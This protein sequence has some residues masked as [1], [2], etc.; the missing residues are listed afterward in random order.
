MTEKMNHN[1]PNN[2][3]KFSGNGKAGFFFCSFFVLQVLFFGLCCPHTVHAGESPLQEL[4]DTTL[5][6]FKAI[7]GKITRVEDRKA[8]IDIGLNEGL[9]PGMRLTVLREQAPFRHPVTKEVLGNL[10]SLTGRMEIQEV[11]EDSA[12][13]ILLEGETQEGDKA[14]ISEV[15]VDILFCQSKEVDWQ[16]AD[17]YHKKLK[18]TGRFT[19]RDTALETDNPATAIDEA[20]KLGAEV[21]LLLSSK[22]G[23]KGMVFTQRLF[24][25]SDGKK[26]AETGVL[27]DTSL[28]KELR[29]GEQFFQIE[30]EVALKFD[31]SFSA[32]FVMTGDV[33]GDGKE[34]II[35]ATD[36]DVG[37]YTPGA[38]LQ[39]AL[40]G[41]K[42]NGAVGSENLWLDV[43]DLN[44]NGK[45]EILVT[46]MKGDSV[47]SSVYEL[48]GSAFVP[49]YEDSLFLRSLGNGMIAQVY[50][51]AEGFSGPVFPISCEAGEY[52]KGEPL[53]LPGKVNIYDFVSYD[54]PRSGRIFIAYDQDRFLNV[55][56]EQGMQVWKRKERTG[57]F[58]ATF[59]KSSPT[60]MIDRGEWTVKDRL[61]MRNG[62]IL[63]AERTPLL[64]VVK[65]LGYKNSQIKKMRWTG[66][67]ME[68]TSFIDG[69]SGTLL[70]Y[71][72]SGDKVLV[73][74]SPVLGLKAGNILKGNN[75]LGSM[76]SIY[77]MKRS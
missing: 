73:L 24:W 67:S 36:T 16:I 66:L 21:A 30:S 22:T 69:I 54:D 9:K 59:K 50:S 35:L 10:E 32:R 12:S 38:D 15:K 11:Y 56:D 27:I 23:E 31:L 76:L 60:S 18:E 26:L 33:N 52:K 51:P 77:S 13:G 48:Q 74:S 44:L 39:A 63:V 7:T 68:E 4:S 25:V 64:G 46:T 62:D 28:E 40:G 5:S 1:L 58:L 6:Y 14:R 70:D 57:G 41:V 45:D 43:I 49:L 2:R 75:P 53:K 20:K 37:I 34:E 19:L 3:M 61:I 42:I 17:A 71:A 47:T 29:F 65:G 72:V 55:Y 8:V